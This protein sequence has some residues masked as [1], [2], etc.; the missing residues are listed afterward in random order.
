MGLASFRFTT[1]L[2][3]RSAPSRVSSASALRAASMNRLDCAGSSWM[4]LGLSV[5]SGLIALLVA[6]SPGFASGNLVLSGASQGFWFQVSAEARSPRVFE[7]ILVF[8]I[9]PKEL[10]SEKIAREVEGVQNGLISCGNGQVCEDWSNQIF[11]V[12]GSISE[13]QKIGKLREDFFDCCS[14]SSR[15]VNEQLDCKFL[16]VRTYGMSACPYGGAH[17]VVN[18]YLSGADGKVGAFQIDDPHLGD[19]NLF[20]GSFGRGLSRSR[21]H[22][23]IADASAHVEQLPNEQTGLAEAN[24][25]EPEREK[26]SSV[27]G[28][29]VPEGAMFYMSLIGIGAFVG[30]LA[31]GWVVTR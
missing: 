8:N 11:F 18:Y 28:D 19:G 22:F 24:Y 29:P 5:I 17:D 12:N 7:N 1:F 13:W 31:I 3:A 27:V 6:L 25:H 4:R 30:G 16:R 23:G 10:F 26:S 14:G 2:K 15:V 21:E 20:F 9:A